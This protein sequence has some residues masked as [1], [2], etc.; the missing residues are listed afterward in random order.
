MTVVDLLRAIGRRWYVII[1]ALA[2]G[3]VAAG[4]FADAAGVYQVRLRLVLLPPASATVDANTLRDPGESLV[5]FAALVE[6]EFRGNSSRARFSSIDAPLFGAGPRSAVSVTL[7]NAGGQWS[8]DFRDAVLYVEAVD[9]SLEQARERMDEAVQ[10]V[11]QIVQERQDAEGVAEPNRISVLVSDETSGARYA[12]G[13]TM[14]ATGA[15]LLLAAGAGIAGAVLL[16][17]AMQRRRGRLGGAAS[18]VSAG[19][20]EL[21]GSAQGHSAQAGSAAHD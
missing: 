5:H 2:L 21:V 13:S 8:T 17:R 1:A 12:H 10:Q 16:D 6:R 20:A 3:A 11:R 9:P 18:V 7:P 15:V 4:V 19:E 14:R